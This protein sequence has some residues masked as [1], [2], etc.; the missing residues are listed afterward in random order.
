MNLKS[1][2]RFIVDSFR[3]SP[4]VRSYEHRRRFG[5]GL[6]EEEAL[7][8]FLSRA[9]GWKKKR[10]I[11]RNYAIDTAYREAIRVDE[12]KRER[13]NLMGFGHYVTGEE[14]DAQWKL[15]ENYRFSD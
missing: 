4:A 12:N 8:R 14:I 7:K 10:G 9:S 1:F 3:G 2:S 11:R 6:T 13:D 15:L 5:G